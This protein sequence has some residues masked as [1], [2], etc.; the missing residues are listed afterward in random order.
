MKTAFIRFKGR[1]NEFLVMG[2]WSTI[3]QLLL[4]CHTALTVYSCFSK[5]LKGQRQ[6]RMIFHGH[7]SLQTPIAGPPDQKM[8]VELAHRDGATGGLPLCKE[9]NATLMLAGNYSCGID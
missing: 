9:A 6:C 2:D 8:L 7:L 5:A 4:C 1:N 3:G